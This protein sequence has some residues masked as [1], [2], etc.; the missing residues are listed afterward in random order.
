MNALNLLDAEVEDYDQ[1][2]FVDPDGNVAEGPNMNLA[3][4]TQDNI[5]VV[6]A[7]VC[8]QMF[9]LSLAACISMRISAACC[10]ARFLLPLHPAPCPTWSADCRNQ[11]RSLQNHIDVSALRASRPQCTSTRCP[12]SQCRA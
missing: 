5:I 4:L 11:A 6:R 7:C 8:L 10:S 12:A 3:I 9:M 1:G 2:V